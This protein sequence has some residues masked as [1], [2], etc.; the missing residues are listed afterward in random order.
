MGC[1]VSRRDFLSVGMSAS[2]GMALH[3]ISR[4][5]LSSSFDLVIVNGNVLDGTGGPAMRV[6]LGIIGETIAAVGVIAPEQGKRTLDATGFHVAP[7]FI[8]VHTHSDSSIFAYPSADSRVRQGI[9]TE[10]TGNC[11]S[12]AA[13]L[14]GPGAEEFR[15]EVLQ[16]HGVFVE[17]TGVGSY[18]ETLEQIGVSTNQAMLLGQGTLRENTIGLENRNLSG[19]ELKSVVRAVEEGLDQ[20]AFGL[21]TGLEY[22][23]GRY[24]PT[25]EIVALARFV[26][27]RGGLYSTHIRNEEAN[28]LAAVHE[29]IQVGRDAGVRVEIS[30][31]KAGGRPNWA[32]QRAA[33]D[34]IEAA[35]SDGVDVMADAYPYTAYS[36]GLTIFMPSWALEGGWP[37][38]ARRLQD[39]ADRSRIRKSYSSQ[40]QADPGDYDL[41]VIASTRSEKNRNL[42]GMNLAEIAVE[43]DVDPVDAALKL[44]LEEEGRVS[45]VGHG[46]SPENVEL[47]LA[48]PLVMIGSDGSSMAPTGRAAETRP[49]PRSYGT[50]TRVLGHYCR[51]RKIFDLPTAIK[52]MTSMAADRVGLR[53]RGRIARG[54]KADLVVF[55][56]AEVRDRAT[57]D[58]PHQY[59]IGVPYVIVNGKLVVEEGRHTGVRSGVVLRQT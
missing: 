41:I 16:D 1:E 8:D 2:L 39:P 5:L 4:I 40:I 33:L 29:A 43:W 10:L 42:I 49:H 9:T 18:F 59:S 14:E 30:H 27:R 34:L 32:K 6:D 20:G 54:N 19:E 58:D 17:W 56:A 31:L 55:D 47:V 46:M 7:G 13:P 44:V 22:T 57:F 12:S 52:K 26:A 15:A 50:C 28:L 36:T 25:G 35:R 24:T 38:L 37:Q 11:G 53:D 45:I 3:P 23:P 51:E 48:H 21:S